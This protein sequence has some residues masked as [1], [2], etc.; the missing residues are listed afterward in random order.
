M[1]KQISNLQITI[2]KYSDLVVR[3]CEKTSQFSVLTYTLKNYYKI[4]AAPLKEK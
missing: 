1:K 3:E 4:E 2:L